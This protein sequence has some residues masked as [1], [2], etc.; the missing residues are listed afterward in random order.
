MARLIVSMLVKHVLPSSLG[1]IGL[2]AATKV[3][4]CAH[5]FTSKANPCR[6]QSSVT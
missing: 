6:H 1:N 5:C 3:V 2:V 4:M